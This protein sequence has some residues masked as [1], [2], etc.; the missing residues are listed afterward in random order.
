MVRIT[1]H[2]QLIALAVL[3]VLVL[4]GVVLAL[5]QGAAAVVRLVGM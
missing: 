4:G 2:L 5:V 1:R 3:A